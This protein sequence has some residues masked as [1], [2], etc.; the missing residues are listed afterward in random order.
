MNYPTFLENCQEDTVKE[1]FEHLYPNIVG[2]GNDGELTSTLKTF[3][4][5][6]LFLKYFI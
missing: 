3:N 1:M 6:C 4:Q 5:V 2:P